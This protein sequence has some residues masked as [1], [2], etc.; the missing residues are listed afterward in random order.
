MVRQA[1]PAQEQPATWRNSFFQRFETPLSG[2]FT[3]QLPLL[4]CG[5][6]EQLRRWAFAAV[7]RCAE[8]RRP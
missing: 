6:L 1:M 3:R 8:H 4:P 7:P 5:H 2:H